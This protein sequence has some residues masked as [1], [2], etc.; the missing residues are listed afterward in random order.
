[1]HA[2]EYGKQLVFVEDQRDRDVVH[3]ALVL[4]FVPPKILDDPEAAV[5]L[6]EIRLL[7]E[8]LANGVVEVLGRI[9]SLCISP[10]E[11]FLIDLLA[12]G[13]LLVEGLEV[14]FD[15]TC[16]NMGRLNTLELD[17]HACRCNRGH[18]Q[19]K[20]VEFI[21]NILTARDVIDGARA[22]F[23]SAVSSLLGVMVGDDSACAVEVV[24]VNQC[25]LGVFQGIETLDERLES[26]LLNPGRSFD[27]RG[28]RYVNH[29]ALIARFF[30]N[31]ATFPVHSL[32]EWRDK[33]SSSLT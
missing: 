12:L 21:V 32:Q 13:E 26:A 4:S 5:G 33:V 11:G 8:L 16:G 3:L 24:I 19:V 28:G 9:S 31:R 29:I 17:A 15:L 18:A 23:V 1:M 14:C 10:V 20:L 2:C 6:F 7:H 30:H 22:R 27:A 25:H